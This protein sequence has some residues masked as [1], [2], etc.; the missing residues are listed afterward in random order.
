MEAV[1][2]VVVRNHEGQ[3]S[4]WDATRAVPAGW[5]VQGPPAP[6]EAC[7]QYI[8][9]NWTDMTPASLRLARAEHLDAR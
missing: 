8:R 3:Y 7:L 5:D 1:E 6:K 4:I 2:F 9:E